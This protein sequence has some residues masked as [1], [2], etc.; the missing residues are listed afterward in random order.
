MTIKP[1]DK[2]TLKTNE[3]RVKSL[4]FRLNMNSY[5]TNQMP[6]ILQ[7]ADRSSSDSSIRSI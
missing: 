5:E 7:E 3:E 1:S 4:L 6:L 2:E